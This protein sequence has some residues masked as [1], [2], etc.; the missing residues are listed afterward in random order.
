MFEK[1][2]AMK[3][4]QKKEQ[5]VIDTVRKAKQDKEVE[6]Q[7]KLLAEELGIDLETAKEYSKIKL[8]KEAQQ[9]IKEDRSKKISETLSK[10][11]DGAQQVAQNIE[12]M[13]EEPIRKKER[14]HRKKEDIK[15]NTIESMSKRYDDFV[16]GGDR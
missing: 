5:E 6:E 12:N 11:S 9:K 8:R 2:R 3:E 1:I 10:I 16:V 15:E 14:K 7:A 4:K 13:G